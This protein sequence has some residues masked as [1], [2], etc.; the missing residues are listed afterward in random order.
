MF[1]TGTI[2]NKTNRLYKRCLRLIYHDKHSTFHE[3]L[4]K[5]FSVSIHTRKLQSFVAEMYKLVKDISPT[6]TQESFK[7]SK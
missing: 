7:V 1:K 5:I 3:L 2:N 4:K 6:I